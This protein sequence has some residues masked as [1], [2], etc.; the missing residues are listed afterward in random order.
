MTWIGITNLSFA[1]YLMVPPPEYHRSPN[2]IIHKRAGQDSDRIFTS[3]L[4]GEVRR[5]KRPPVFTGDLFSS[6]AELEPA[7]FGL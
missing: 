5:I 6:G 1:D 2:P 3:P 4:F 7:A